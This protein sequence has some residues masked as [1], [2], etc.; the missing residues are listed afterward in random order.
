MN[1]LLSI[2]RIRRDDVVPVAGPNLPIRRTQVV[3][4]PQPPLSDQQSPSSV[5]V[6]TVTGTVKGIA[7]IAT[8]PF[9]KK[10][11]F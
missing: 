4:D 8:C 11:C 10:E 1:N 7:H 3:P 6:K 5:A 9:T 2:S